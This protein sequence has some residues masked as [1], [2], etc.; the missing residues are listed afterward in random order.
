MG[1][2]EAVGALEKWIPEHGYVEGDACFACSHEQA[3]KPPY[4]EYVY[5]KIEEP[6]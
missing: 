2:G 3:E 4:I 1:V 6:S 5:I